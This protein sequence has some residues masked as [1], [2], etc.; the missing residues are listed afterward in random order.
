MRIWLNRKKNLSFHQI[1]QND[2]I[3]PMLFVCLY[4]WFVLYRNANYNCQKITVEWMYIQLFDLQRFIKLEQI[5]RIEIS[6]WSAKCCP[7]I[8]FCFLY[9]FLYQFYSLQMYWDIIIKVSRCIAKKSIETYSCNTSGQYPVWKDWERIIMVTIHKTNGHFKKRLIL[10]FC[11]IFLFPFP[12]HRKDKSQ[13]V[14]PAYKYQW[15]N[16]WGDFLHCD[17]PYHYLCYS[18][19]QTAS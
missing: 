16:H 1:V 5:Q 11:F 2:I 13:P 18:P 4:A 3:P 15:D 14:G 7:A 17:P 12:S 9:S 8:Y 10:I 19:D 6:F